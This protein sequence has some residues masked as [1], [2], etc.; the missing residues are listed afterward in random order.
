MKGDVE[1]GYSHS[2]AQKFYKM[3]KYSQTCINYEILQKYV[4]KK[5]MRIVLKEEGGLKVLILSINPK[6]SV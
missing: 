2:F 6:A 1:Y 3:G 5:I 4:K